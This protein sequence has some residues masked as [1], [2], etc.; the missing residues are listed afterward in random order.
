MNLDLITVA[1]LENLK[2]E[3][4][5]E[6]RNLTTAKSQNSIRMYKSKHVKEILG[7]SD[8]TL[9]NLRINGSLHPK[10]VGGIYYYLPEEIHALLGSEYIG[11]RH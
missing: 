7:C 3:I 9:Q 11:G 2:A 6:M 8:G 1:D 5:A 4:M 10:K